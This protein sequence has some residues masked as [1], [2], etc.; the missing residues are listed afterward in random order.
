MIEVEKYDKKKKREEFWSSVQSS[1]KHREQEMTKK[2]NNE[3]E[4]SCIQNSITCEIGLYRQLRVRRIRELDESLS[5]YY[6]FS[7]LLI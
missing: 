1:E 4:P 3:E 5:V 7:G 2:K 6:C